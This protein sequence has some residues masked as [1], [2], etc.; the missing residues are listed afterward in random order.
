V[1]LHFNSTQMLG[2]GNAA[3]LSS[4]SCRRGPHALWAQLWTDL[5]QEHRGLFCGVKFVTALG[6]QPARATSNRAATITLCEGP[7][8]GIIG[9]V[10]VASTAVRCSIC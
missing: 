9:E 10:L 6:A 5:H 8:G 3:I 4:T 1:F 7:L 2:P